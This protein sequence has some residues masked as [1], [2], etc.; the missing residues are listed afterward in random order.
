MDKTGWIKSFNEKMS[1]SLTEK[2]GLAESKENRC[3]MSPTAIGSFFFN[4]YSSFK[5]ISKYLYLKF[6]DS[7]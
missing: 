1:N 5:T 2:V 6:N 4:S 3:V 7:F